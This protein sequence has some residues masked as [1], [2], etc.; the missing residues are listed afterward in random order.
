M[1][2]KYYKFIFMLLFG[3]FVF[4]PKNTFAYSKIELSSSNGTVL[5]SSDNMDPQ[6]VNIDNVKFIIFYY[7]ISLTSQSSYTLNSEFT[8]STYGSTGNGVT[9]SYFLINK[10]IQNFSDSWTP[11]TQKYLNQFYHH[12]YINHIEFTSNYS[13][14]VQAQ[15]TYTL[16]REATIGTVGFYNNSLIFTGSN[17][18]EINE[19]INSSTTNIINNDNSNTNKILEQEKKLQ[20]EQQKTNEALT[21]E[22]S[23]DVDSFFDD[24]N[25]DDSNSPVSDLITMPI[26]L[27]QAYVNGFSSSC[28]P[29]SLGT[30]YGYTLTLPCINLEEYL[31]GT[32]WSLID[33]LFSIFMVYNIAMLCVS[34]YESIT[35]LDDGMQQLYTPQHAGHSRVSRGE[36]GGLY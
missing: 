10:T 25:I 13:G 2:K 20:E 9:L 35:S 32:L 36:M 19:S 18:A 7:D 21:S 27:M 1:V 11:I 15:F 8:Y 4:M 23:P 26:T 29:V 28:S 14:T 33:A 12:R 6:L 34:I 30:L 17:S 16:S 5:Y 3:F 31:G 24:L 22:E